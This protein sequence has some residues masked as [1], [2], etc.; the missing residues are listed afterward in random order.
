MSIRHHA[1]GPVR[2]HQPPRHARPGI[3]WLQRTTCRQWL[4]LMVVGLTLVGCSF[5]IPKSQQLAERLPQDWR[6]PVAAAQVWQALSHDV[7]AHAD[8]L[9]THVPEYHVLSWCEKVTQWRDLG[10]DTV[11]PAAL[12]AGMS[13]DAFAKYTEA[14]GE[15]TA[16]TTIWVEDLGTESRV[17]IR[18]VYFG[19]P[20]LAGVGHSRGE[21]ERAF[22]QQ[23][24]TRLGLRQS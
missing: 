19:A 21:Y 18:R 9:L 15:G 5:G 12:S 23:L 3:W 6:L 10:Q 2:T 7:H 14:S 20:S 16:V 4:G 1:C 24:L 8:C 22:Y 17:H 13:A 11:G